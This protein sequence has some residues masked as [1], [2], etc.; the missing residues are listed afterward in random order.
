[1][2]IEL[3]PPYSD[4]WKSG[5]LV[6][7]KEN[8][9]TVIL[10]N[11]GSDRS[12]TQYA[13]Y[14]LAVSMGRFLTAEETVDHIDGDKTNDNIDNL[15]ILTRAENISKACKQPDVELT[16]PV[17]GNVF[18]RT[19]TQLRGRKHRAEEN[20]IACSRVCG[21]KVNHITKARSL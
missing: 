20:M 11:S 7:N 8:R 18:Y 1:M 15:Q 5:Y 6:T 19:L 17:C 14:L 9:K 12:S 4:K 2:K 13:R 21:G 10:V 16:C 3:K